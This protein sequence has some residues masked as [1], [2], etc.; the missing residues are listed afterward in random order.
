VSYLCPRNTPA[1]PS[2]DQYGRTWKDAQGW[3]RGFLVTLADL[4]RRGLH[5]SEVAR[6]KRECL[7]L[8]RLEQARHEQ[9]ER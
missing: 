1:L 6:Y 2:W 4:N 8:A 3:V 5:R 7:A 9:R